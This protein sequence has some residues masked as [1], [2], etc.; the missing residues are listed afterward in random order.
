MSILKK[1]LAV[2]ALLSPVPAFAWGDVGHLSVCGVAWNHMT[3]TTKVAVGKILG[4][5]PGDATWDYKFARQCVWPDEVK[6]TPPWSTTANFH[7]IN[8]EVVPGEIAG[9]PGNAWDDASEFAGTGDMLQAL[10]AAKDALTD[11]SG[12]RSNDN[13]KCHLRLLGHLGGDSHQPMHY[14]KRS[15][16]G[17]N[18]VQIHWRG[19]PT[20]VIK[21]MKI[22]DSKQEC[23]QRGDEDVGKGCTT[24]EPL[25]LPS[26]LHSLWDDVFIDAR[27]KEKLGV[28]M[29]ANT[30]NPFDAFP[31]FV[32]YLETQ[33]QAQAADL[34]EK[35]KDDFLSWAE[36]TASKRVK[37]A[38][39]GITQTGTVQSD[40]GPQGI[41]KTNDGD[42]KYYQDRISVIEQQI[43]AGGYHLAG[44]LNQIFDPQYSGVLGQRLA[45]NQARETELRRRI[46]A[47]RLP[48]MIKAQADQKKA[49]EDLVKAGKPAKPLPF[50]DKVLADA[51][52]KGTVPA[53]PHACDR[54]LP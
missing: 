24:V 45:F 48:A 47:A 9:N 27:L 14:G 8:V 32:A 54:N 28:D 52:A 13:K 11:T 29:A 7:F 42:E 2:A 21:S 51:Q 38:Y 16:L 46:L 5:K 17:G 22:D 33:S 1:S 10:I 36:L 30:A 53:L 18:L 4:V 6:K 44:M 12:K 43:T 3:Q 20:I 23:F 34:T 35:M 39:T 15:D 26:N 41:Y 31:K 40:R 50:D 37:M 19:N 49:N 25:Q